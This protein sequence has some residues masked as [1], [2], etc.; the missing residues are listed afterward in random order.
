MTITAAIEV[1]TLLLGLGLIGLFW[2]FGSLWRAMVD[3]EGGIAHGGRGGDR[4]W[5]G[6]TVGVDVGRHQLDRPRCSSEPSA[7]RP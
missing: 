6:G 1:G 7:H 5:G 4:A 3:A 2:W